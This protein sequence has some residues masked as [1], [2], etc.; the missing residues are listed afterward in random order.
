MGSVRRSSRPVATV[1]I[2][3][4]VAIAACNVLNGADDLDL[5][6]G[7]GSCDELLGPDGSTIEGATFSPTNNPSSSDDGGAF[8]SAGP[9]PDSNEGASPCPTCEAGTCT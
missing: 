9:S 6:D 4:T 1:G 7:G 2:L 8:D 3:A 5:C